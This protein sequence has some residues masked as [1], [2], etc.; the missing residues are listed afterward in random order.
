MALIRVWPRAG[1]LVVLLLALACS[2]T[3]GCVESNFELAPESRLPVWITIP[4]GKQRADVR[5]DLYYWGPVFDVANV[6][7]VV[8]SA[9]GWRPWGRTTVYGRSTTHPRSDPGILL[10]GKRAYEIVDV[11]GQVDVIEHR[12]YSEQNRDKTRAL[13]WMCDDP[14]ILREAREIVARQRSQPRSSN[15]PGRR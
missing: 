5:V 4:P 14:D 7:L 8:S 13:F 2:P 15:S 9:P 3:R 11:D 1:L 6:E 10:K 12:D